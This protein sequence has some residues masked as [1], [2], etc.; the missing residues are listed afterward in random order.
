MILRMTA[1]NAPMD[2]TVHN[3]MILL[4]VLPVTKVNICQVMSPAIMRAKQIVK[5]V[6]TVD[7]AIPDIRLAAGVMREDSSMI[8]Q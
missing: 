8:M 5:Y 3:N 2:I 4:L 7:I 6:S 1:I